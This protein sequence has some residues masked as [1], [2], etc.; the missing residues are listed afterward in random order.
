M[1]EEAGQIHCKVET[2]PLSAISMAEF[3]HRIESKQTPYSS[4]TS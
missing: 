4:I 3:P 2:S 1:F